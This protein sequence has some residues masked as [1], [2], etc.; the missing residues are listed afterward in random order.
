MKLFHVTLGEN[1]DG[2]HKYGVLPA[3]ST[4]RKPRTW[5]IDR[6]SVIWGIAHISA[7]YRVPVTKLAVCEAQIPSNF[8]HRWITPGVYYVRVVIHPEVYW[9]YEAFVLPEAPDTKAQEQQLMPI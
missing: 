6:E 5:W 4:G 7:R 2:I 8:Y 1:L 9:G 3:L